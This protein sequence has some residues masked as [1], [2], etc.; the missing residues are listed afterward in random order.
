LCKDSVEERILEQAKH[1]MMLDT[2]VQQNSREMVLKVL[3]FG[4]KK[5]FEKSNEENKEQV[6]R[7]Y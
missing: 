6:N 7:E 5:L 2:A 1:K 3:A 4:T